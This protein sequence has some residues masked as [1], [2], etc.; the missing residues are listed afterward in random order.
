MAQ[1]PD[2]RLAALQARRRELLQRLAVA[3][4]RAVVGRRAGL[5]VLEGRLRA[6]SPLAVLG[7]G[8]ALVTDETGVV[9]R[10]ASA[11]LPGQG[12]RVRLQ[13][14]VLRARVEEALP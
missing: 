11:A 1:R 3:G 12:I 9:L 7:R 10:R 2:R 8:Y 14:G 6:L 4:A 13:E 5:R